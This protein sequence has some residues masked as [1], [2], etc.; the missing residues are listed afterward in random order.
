[1]TR[2]MI[3]A[4]VIFAVPLLGIHF[5]A[6]MFVEQTAESDDCPSARPGSRAGQPLRVPLG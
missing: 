5:Y 2:V 1:M 6:G 4:A 3:L